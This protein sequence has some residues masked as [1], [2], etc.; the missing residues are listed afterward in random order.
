M[1]T[2]S[3]KSV[4][5]HSSRCRDQDQ[6]QEGGQVCAREGFKGCSGLVSIQKGFMEPSLGVVI[7][8]G[9]DYFDHMKRISEHLGRISNFR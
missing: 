1:L 7:L 6:G 9:V 4:V 3:L 5:N 8:V 2:T